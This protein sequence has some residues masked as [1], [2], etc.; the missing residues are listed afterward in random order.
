MKKITSGNKYYLPK[1]S[2]VFTYDED[3]NPLVPFKTT[4]DYI[5]H[6]MCVGYI[7]KYHLIRFFNIKSCD[8]SE[9]CFFLEKTNQ[10]VLIKDI[11]QLKTLKEFDEK[12]RNKDSS[13]TK[14][15]FE[16]ELYEFLISSIK[17][18]NIYQRFGHTYI[19][20]YYLKHDS[21]GTLIF[22][23]DHKQNDLLIN[24]WFLEKLKDIFSEDIYEKM[25]ILDVLSSICIVFEKIMHHN[26]LTYRIFI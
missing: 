10:N 18:D 23:Y 5:I 6:V 21:P 24:N 7:T 2:T 15:K 17:C 19:E 16:D 1:G 22:H 25:H 14:E 3:V 26:P 9:F 11:S 13:N 8:N 12:I 4:E 20:Y